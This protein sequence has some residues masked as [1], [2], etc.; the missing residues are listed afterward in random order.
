VDGATAAPVKKARNERL[1]G[2]AFEAAT[3]VS[4]ALAMVMELCS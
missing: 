4:V 1:A 3:V 2:T